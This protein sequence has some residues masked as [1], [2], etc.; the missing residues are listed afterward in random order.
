MLLYYQNVIQSIGENR[1]NGVS[2]IDDDNSYPLAS[3]L[4]SRCSK[5]A[6]DSCTLSSPRGSSKNRLFYCMC[7]LE[8]L[9]TLF[10]IFVFFFILSFVYLGGKLVYY[11]RLSRVEWM[12][13]KKAF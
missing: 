8:Y 11:S 1:T 4:D 7:P 6:F 13:F 3:N 10:I 12:E 9:S 5:K 2:R